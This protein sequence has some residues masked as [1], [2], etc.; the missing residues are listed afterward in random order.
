MTRVNKKQID[1]KLT[2]AALEKLFQKVRNSKS[3]LDLMTNLKSFLT[4][5]EIC[6]LEKRLL[7]SLLLDQKLSY[8][9]IGQTID[10]TRTT[11]SFVKH[12]LTRRPAVY[13]KHISNI[14]PKP[15]KKLPLIPSRAE[16]GRWL[17][18]KL[19]GRDY[20]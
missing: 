15:R 10:V 9:A 16:H 4:Q 1:Q 11:I 14:V 6:L 2:D 5:S 3:G 13:R 17:R 7:I 20:Y 8:R 19:S 18:A 12:N